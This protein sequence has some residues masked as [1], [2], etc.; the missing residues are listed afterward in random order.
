M[1]KSVWGQ[2]RKRG[3]G[4]REFKNQKAKIKYQNHKIKCKKEDATQSHRWGEAMRHSLKQSVTERR[5]TQPSDILGLRY[6]LDENT[7]MMSPEL[8]NYRLELPEL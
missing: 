5:T 4:D 2:F 8:R 7:S 1:H 3:I 6:S